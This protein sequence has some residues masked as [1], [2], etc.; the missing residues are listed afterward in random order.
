MPIVATSRGYL[1]NVLWDAEENDTYTISYAP[2]SVRTTSGTLVKSALGIPVIWDN[3]ISAFRPLANSDTIPATAST[4]PNNA[5]VGIV[6]G[7]AAGLGDDKADITL[8][9]TP[10]VLTVAFRDVAVVK[11]GITYESS[12]LSPTRVVFE[13]QLEKQSVVVRAKSTA[14]TQSFVA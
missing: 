6:V 11:E 3:A 5:P 10:Q 14:I 7:S 4:L 8:S 1:S 13:A 9:T 2:A 12:V